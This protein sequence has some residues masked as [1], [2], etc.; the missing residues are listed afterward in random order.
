MSAM[1]S[2]NP[3][4]L[5]NGL[6]AVARDMH[7]RHASDRSTPANLGAW[8]KRI[9]RLVTSLRSACG[10][11]APAPITLPAD[12]VD[13]CLQFEEQGIQ[14]EWGIDP[15]LGH[16][17]DFTPAQLRTFARQVAQDEATA[18]AK[19]IER[20]AAKLQLIMEAHKFN[21]ASITPSEVHELAVEVADILLGSEGGQG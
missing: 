19:R 16:L 10:V 18:N 6:N 3:V 11:P 13:L 7:E 4:D 12:D 1:T 15:G 14:V 17:I 8:A 5:L 20:A 9:D 2:S 21:V